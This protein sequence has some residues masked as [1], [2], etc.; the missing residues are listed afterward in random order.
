MA[1][2]SLREGRELPC[3]HMASEE[4]DALAAALRCVEILESIN[5]NDAFDF[6]ARVLRELRELASHPAHLANHSANHASALRIG[7]IGKREP[8]IE[9]RR[10]AERRS[11]CVSK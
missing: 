6:L 1:V 5:D 10:A 2:Q 11:H 3:A 7:P 9:H 8:E 4:Q